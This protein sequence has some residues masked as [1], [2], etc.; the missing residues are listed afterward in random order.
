M[1]LNDFLKA[2]SR[3]QAALTP[4]LEAK[5]QTLCARL[6]EASEE[7][8]QDITFANSLGAEDML[9]TGCLAEQSLAIPLFVLDTGRLPEPTLNLLAEVQKRWPQLDLQVFYPAPEAL[10][11]WVKQ[12]GINAF[13][14]S[15][16]LRKSCCA[17]RKLEPLQRA[18]AGKQAW[19][20]GLRRAQSITR[21]QLALREWDAA[22]Q[23]TKIN[24][25]FDWEEDEV[26]QVLRTRHW[27]YNILH[28]QGYPSLGCAPCTRAIE[29][30]ADPR[31]GRWWW[32]QA[33]QRECGL[34][35]A[36]PTQVTP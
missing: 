13:Y 28:D 5:Y 1:S 17:L 27:P 32:E 6:K 2:P 4:A 26:W 16:E 21:E 11:A 22:Q 7:F 15:I 36:R 14:R 23:L 8:G 10:Q 24:P 29:P 33:E 3:A 35:P 20:T 25:L 31:S 30:G 34:H 12:E 18:L 19:I 9:I